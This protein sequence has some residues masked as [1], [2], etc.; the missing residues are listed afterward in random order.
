MVTNPIQIVATTMDKVSSLTGR[1]EQGQPSQI[2]KD[3]VMGYKDL[4]MEAYEFNAL[5]R[6]ATTPESIE[7]LTWV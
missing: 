4:S 3:E 2:F 7:F 6:H 5:L 1:I